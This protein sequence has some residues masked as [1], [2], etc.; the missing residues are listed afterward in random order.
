MATGRSDKRFASRHSNPMEATAGSTAMAAP[1]SP[2]IDTGLDMKTLRFECPNTGR[3]VD[4]GIN[5]YRHA[6]M[7]STRVRCP[8]CEDLHEWRVAEDGVATDLSVDR[9]AKDLRL[10]EAQ[11]A[12]LEFHG[13]GTQT[14][15]LREQLLDELNH[16][17]KNNLQILYAILQ[18]AFRRTGNPE[19]RE[20]L[21]DTSRRIAAMAT[22]QQA[23]YS[24]HNS[25]DVS[26]P[27]FIEAVCVNARVFFSKE[28][29]IK[30]AA[31][32]G[33][34]PKET[35]M[36]L[37]LVLNELITNAAKHGANERGR[38]SIDVGLRQRSGSHELHVQDHGRGFKL[39]DAQVRR[40]GLGLVTELTQQL[41]GT[42]TVERRSGARCTLRF[43]D[44]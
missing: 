42:F 44:R 25:T 43:P 27:H 8:I 23:F 39:E 31:T 6:Y 30:Y 29:S 5:T 33:S 1:P 34:L 37:A 35:A 41:K 18:A 9:P 4:S 2:Q 32:A 20:V 17:L 16:R 19:A 21:S 36:P 13:P 40:S 12:L 22:A 14:I 10:A 28:V 24:V 15:E 3:V 11:S 38:V 7:V 26:G